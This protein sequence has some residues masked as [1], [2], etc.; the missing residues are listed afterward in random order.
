QRRRRRVRAAGAAGA[1][2]RPPGRQRGIRLGAFRPRRLPGD[3]PPA[4]RTAGRRRGNHGASALGVI[5]NAAAKFDLT[6][7]VAIGTGGGKGIGARVAE[8][9]AA[10]GADIA[11]A[12]RHQDTLDAVAGQVRLRGRRA[13]AVRTDVQ[14][15]AE[16]NALV[17]RT[18][19]A[20]GRVD[21]LVNN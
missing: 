20:F 16:V 18:L 3:D 21:I 13:L 4:E 12:G 14:Q 8:A 15:V 10:A 17:A 11:V 9:L 7:R 5:M 19:E 2:A 6:E 1:G